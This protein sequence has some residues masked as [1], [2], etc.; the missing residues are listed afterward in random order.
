MQTNIT[1]LQEISKHGV[2]THKGHFHA[3]D[4]LSASLLKITNIIHDVRVI[5]RVGAVPDNFDGLVFDIG[6]GEF[7]HHQENAKYRSNGSKYA[8]FGLLWRSIGTEY[9]MQKYNA[10]AQDAKKAADKFDYDFIVPMDLT[11]NF[12][13]GNYPNT[14]SYLIASRNNGDF[15][16]TERDEI[17]YKIANDFC[18][19]LESMIKTSYDFVNYQTQAIKISQK[20]PSGIAI[21]DVNDAFIPRNAFVGTNIKCII[22]LTDRGTYNIT[23]IDPYKIDNSFIKMPG[24]VQVWEIGAAFKT[25]ENAKDAATQFVNNINL[26]K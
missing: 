2:I 24:C 1:K 4:I 10:T 3:D 14:L 23:T 22:K 19:Y 11:D 12:G 8:S 25:L 9:I 20:N 6:K 5:Q 16:T 26:S 13:Q 17:F 18:E 21:F 15:T 7:D